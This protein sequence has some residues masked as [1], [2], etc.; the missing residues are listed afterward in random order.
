MYDCKASDP[1]T[2]Q[3]IYLK[4]SININFSSN[5]P[6]TKTKS[7]TKDSKYH[8]CTMTIIIAT[9]IKRDVH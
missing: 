2:G 9:V 5:K 3:R 6:K 1:D 4:I 7:K 8:N